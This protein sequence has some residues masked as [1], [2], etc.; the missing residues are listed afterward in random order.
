M[1]RVIKVLHTLG[2]IGLMDAAGAVW[3]PKLGQPASKS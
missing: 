1:V 3:R 2:A